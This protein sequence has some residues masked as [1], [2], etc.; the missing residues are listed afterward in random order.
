M[1]REF[2]KI[3]TSENKNESYTRNSPGPG[4]SKIANDP[5]QSIQMPFL[6]TFDLKFLPP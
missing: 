4:I 2:A 5:R 1:D 6:M 3:K